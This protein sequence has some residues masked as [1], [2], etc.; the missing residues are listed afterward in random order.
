MF[1]WHCNY[2][3]ESR[4]ISDDEIALIRASVI[5]YTNIVMEKLSK[6]EDN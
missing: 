3:K 4:G 2:R 1:L 6:M 5:T